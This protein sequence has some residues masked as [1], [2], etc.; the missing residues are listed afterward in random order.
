MVFRS[1][2]V[3]ISLL[4]FS[5]PF[6]ASAQTMGD[7]KSKIKIRKKTK[8]QRVTTEE[9]V[10]LSEEKFKMVVSKRRAIIEDIKK[11]IRDS[12]D[13]EQ[14]AE[15]NLRLADLYREDY[16]AALAMAQQNFEVQNAAFKKNS[17]NKTAPKF[18]NTEALVSLDKARSIYKDLVVRYPK[19]P[20]RDE[21]LYF[22]AMSSLDRGQ[23]EEA[24]GQFKRLVEE[25]VNSKY[26][27]DAF[28]QLG[29]YYFDQNKFKEA[30]KYYDQLVAKKFKPLMAYVIYKK[31]WC[32]Y[33]EQKPQ[34]AL[35][36]FKWVI[37]NESPE[38]SGY[39]VRVR[40]E[41]IRD[42][43]LPFVD[44]K[45]IDDSIAFFKSLGDPNTRNGL[46]TMA[47]LYY[48][49]G[50]YKHSIQLNEL[51]LAMDGNHPKNPSYD[52]AIIEALK[53]QGQDAAAN[54]RLFAHTPSYLAGSNWYEINSANPKVIQEAHDGYEELARKYAFEYHAQGQKTKNEALYN[55]AK[56][57]YSKYIEFFPKTAHTSKVRF[58]LA[59]IL[60]KQK[61]FFPAAEHYWLVYKDPN[62]G[63]LRGEAIKYALSAL[64]QQLNLDRKKAGTNRD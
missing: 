44:L 30:E 38:Q 9:S 40:N 63:G 39:A 24:M 58:Y 59:E 37:Q 20:R 19:H 51:L 54:A 29:D 45:L 34:N 12:R 33:N 41:A 4:C 2:A 47:A 46:E 50:D 27:T 11:F 62:A 32:A 35:A 64:D 25:N 23:T 5:S 61:T 60:Y 49:Q 56:Q 1:L 55:S 42:I 57:M 3:G 6:E 22:M 48:E 31:G 21:M 43:A 53:I 13:A 10:E 15:L 18:D 36:D 14:V 8:L 17:K 52:I 7:T 16:R 28:V 26:S